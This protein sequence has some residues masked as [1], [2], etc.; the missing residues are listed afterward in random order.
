MTKLT[1]EEITN[2]EKALTYHSN[3]DGKQLSLTGVPLMPYCSNYSTSYL[4][5]L[6]YISL[7][8]TGTPS[9]RLNKTLNEYFKIVNVSNLKEALQRIKEIQENK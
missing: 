7:N 3:Y 9:E 8:N 1:K 4:R 6:G 5:V 2:I